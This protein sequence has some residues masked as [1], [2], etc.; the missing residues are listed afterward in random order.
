MLMRLGALGDSVRVPFTTYL[1]A[2]VNLV[3]WLALVFFGGVGL[4]AT[5]VDFFQG[6]IHRPRPLKLA[7]YTRC[8]ARQ[9]RHRPS[10]RGADARA[11][12]GWPGTRPSW[13]SMP[14]S[15]WS[16]GKRLK[17][18]RKMSVRAPHDCGGLWA[19]S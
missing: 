9:H 11:H 4:I 19:L 1:I 15:F 7:A 17:R 16:A 5:P 6:F 14:R 18:R 10:W 13:A 2:M 12:A 3:G 8:G